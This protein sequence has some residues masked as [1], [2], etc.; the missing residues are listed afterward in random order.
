[1]NMLS[2]RP[3]SIARF[4]TS[5]QQRSA[6]R[7]GLRSSY[8]TVVAGLFIAVL[9]GCGPTWYLDR[10]FAERLAKQENR[11]ILYYFKNWDSPQHRDM[12]LRVFGQPAVQKEMMDT[13]N[14]ELEFSWDRDSARRLGV[15]RTQVCVMCAPSGEKVYQ[16]LPVN[17]IPSEKE[18]LEWIVR[19][20]AEAKARLPVPQS[21][22]PTSQPSA[23]EVKGQP[24]TPEGK[25]PSAKPPDRPRQ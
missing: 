11:P 5:S 6:R 9:G 17:P 20:K 22:A 1:M 14:I 23:S 7:F 13:V 24:A 8:A 16:P 25:G 4:N 2:N 12:K 10:G 15:Q 19:A 18:F 3:S 21:G